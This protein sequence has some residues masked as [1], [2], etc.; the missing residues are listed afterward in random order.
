MKSEFAQIIQKGC[1]FLSMNKFKGL[2]REEF[3]KRFS[4]TCVL[5]LVL[6]A[7]C[8]LLADGKESWGAT[9]DED[10]EERYKSAIVFHEIKY[11]DQAINQLKKIVED[12]PDSKW[13]DD[14]RYMIGYFYLYDKKDFKNAISAYR[15]FLKSHPDHGYAMRAQVEIGNSHY[16]QGEYAAA[17]DAYRKVIRDYTT[18]STVRADLFYRIGNSYLWLKDY[19]SSID[20]YNKIVGDHGD[21]PLA[22]SAQYQIARAYAAS[23]D[24]SKAKEA[25]GEVVS[26]FSKSPLALSAR[27]SI[28]LL[29]GLEEVAEET[30]GNIGVDGGESS[31]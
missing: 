9:P 12:H 10:A 29:G 21:L 27:R 6:V 20:E 7:S 5:V 26:R 19:Q 22:A 23:G 25:Y 31:E 4:N 13:S 1:G 17:I 16:L 14:A 28:D 30:V 8:L 15:S 11:Y 2:G 18:S 24:V 3:M